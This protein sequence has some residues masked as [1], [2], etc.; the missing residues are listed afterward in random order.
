MSILLYTTDSSEKCPDGFRLYSE[1]GVRACDRPVSSGSSCAGITFSSGNIEYSQVCG[2]VIGYQVAFPYG[3]V[4]NDIDGDYIDGISLTH[5]SPHKHIWNLIWT[6]RGN[7]HP[8]ECS[9]GTSGA[10]F[11]ISFFFTEVKSQY[12]RDVTKISQYIRIKQWY[13]YFVNK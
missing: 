12:T 11:V 13:S 1:N 2:K 3:P 6:A 4:G 8:S 10:W 7:A 9:C 5:S